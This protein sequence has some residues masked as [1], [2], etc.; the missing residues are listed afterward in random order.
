MTAELRD[1]FVQFYCKLSR[2]EKPASEGRAPSSISVATPTTGNGMETECRRLCA[3]N[4]PVSAIATSTVLTYA[5]AKAIFHQHT[6]TPS[7]YI[8]LTLH[9]MS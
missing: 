3:Y 1:W 5:V 7:E 6:H 8:M 4:F 2:F 9:D